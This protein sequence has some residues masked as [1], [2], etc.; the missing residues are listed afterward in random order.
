MGV[1]VPRVVVGMRL[2]VRSGEQ[3][4]GIVIVTM[5]MLVVAI[6]VQL[7]LQLERTVQSPKARRGP[8]PGVRVPM[9][10]VHV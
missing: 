6:M 1:G 2:G 9:A 3:A 4:G 7:R 10:V 8:G 5:V